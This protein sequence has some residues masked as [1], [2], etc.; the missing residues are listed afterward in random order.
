MDSRKLIAH[1]PSSLTIA[2]PHRWV[3][4]HALAK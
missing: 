1:G 2:L 3:K 4:K